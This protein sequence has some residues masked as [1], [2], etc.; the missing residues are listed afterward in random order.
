M[1]VSCTRKTLVIFPGAASCVPWK[2]HVH[3]PVG[4]SDWP[5]T[6]LYPIVTEKAT[7]VPDSATLGQ[8]FVSSLVPAASGPAE[9]LLR[10]GRATFWA[11]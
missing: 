1:H 3:L 2:P 10:T 4:P 5:R 11:L 9:L 6:P 8:V 7:G